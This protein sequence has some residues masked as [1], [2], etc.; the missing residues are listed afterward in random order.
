MPDSTTV[1]GPVREASAISRTGLVSVEVKYSVRRLSA[2]ARTRPTMT[3]PKQ[4]QPA[5]NLS[6]PTYANARIAVPTLLNRPA[7]RWRGLRGDNADLAVA[8]ARPQR[9]HTNQ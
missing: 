7:L 4:R 2:W 1:A 8:V 9:A 5:S 3:A 6:L